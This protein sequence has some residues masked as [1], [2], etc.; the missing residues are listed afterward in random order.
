MPLYENAYEPI[1]TLAEAT[2]ET[3]SLMIPEHGFGVYLL[4]EST[5]DEPET[6]LRE[7]ERVPL[8]ATAAGKAILAYLP[9]AEREAIL[10][11]R[12]LPALTDETITDR[13][14]LALEL[15]E[16]HDKRMAHDRGEL[17]PDRD[18]LA[19][20]VTDGDD[21]A[22][23][24]ISISGPSEQMRRKASDMDFS[25]ILGSTANSVRNRLFRR[26]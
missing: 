13:G 23:G 10:D 14:E 22:V 3:V 26:L 9:E 19:A 2:D 25:S 20:P 8:H 6:E 12:G 17:E 24:A 18:C 5:A 1:A 4:R 15:D 7:G 11:E 21:R 16:V